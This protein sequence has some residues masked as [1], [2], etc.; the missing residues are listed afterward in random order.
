LEEEEPE[1]SFL[2]VNEGNLTVF[3]FGVFEDD[4]EDGDDDDKDDIVAVF[5]KSMLVVIVII[6]VLYRKDN[7]LVSCY[8]SRDLSVVLC[9]QKTSYC[10]TLLR[11][12]GWWVSF[13]YLPIKH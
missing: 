3:P 9:I 13:N 6:I 4:D 11:C 8:C 5:V 1:S 10:C 12:S 2:S 7:C